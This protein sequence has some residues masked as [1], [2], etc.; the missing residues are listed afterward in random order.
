MKKTI[1]STLVIIAASAA[2][3]A[4]TYTSGTNTNPPQDKAAALFPEDVQKV[5]ETSCNDCHSEA[6]SN[7][8]AKAKLNLTKWG[9]LSD[10]KKVGKMEAI[11]DEITKGAM[12]PEKYAAKYPDHAMTTASKEI[13][14]KW[15][16]EESAKLMGN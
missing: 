1:L 13:V 7:V 6:S 4:F 9:E 16:T 2:V 10:S 12:P 15:V 14:T 5:F 8:K 11:K 3:M